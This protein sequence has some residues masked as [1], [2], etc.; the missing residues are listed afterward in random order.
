M[1]RL[2]T[3]RSAAADDNAAAEELPIEKSSFVLLLFVHPFPLCPAC[4][5]LPSLLAQIEIE[6]LLS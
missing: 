5:L 4:N 2:V 6:N 1:Q 3:R